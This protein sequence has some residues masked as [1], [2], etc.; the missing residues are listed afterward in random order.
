M[1]PDHD[2]LPLKDG[3]P[4]GGYGGGGGHGGYGGRDDGYGGGH[5]GGG[6]GPHGGYGGPHGGAPQGGPG[7]PGGPGQ[8]DYS[9]QW[10]EYY[11]SLGMVRGEG[12]GSGIMDSVFAF[13][14]T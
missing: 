7:G 12:V 6:G 4:G 8:P 10:A 14:T 5:G 13:F 11:R 2:L 9:A 1:H 3:S